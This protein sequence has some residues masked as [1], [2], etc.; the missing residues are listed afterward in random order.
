MNHLGS[1]VVVGE[2]VLDRAR[3]P[4]YP[5]CP[6]KDQKASCRKRQFEDFPGGPVAE[7]PPA[8]TRDTGSIPALERFHMPQRRQAVRHSC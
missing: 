6:Q 8:D 1:A 5:S 2:G 3:G 7:N 4:L